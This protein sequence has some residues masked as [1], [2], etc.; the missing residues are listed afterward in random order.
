M[1]EG[2]PMAETTL[3]VRVPTPLLRL[4]LD[5][6]AVQRRIAEWLVLSLFTE[7]HISS[8]K[9]AHL[10]NISRI[11]FLAVLRARGI[12]YINYTPDELAEEFAAVETL[13]VVPAP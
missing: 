2:K 9:A 10:M 1:K 12:A 13:E 7:G 11:E 5:Q 3:Q 6:N 4:G 8:G